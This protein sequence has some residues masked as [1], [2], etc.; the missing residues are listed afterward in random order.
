[1]NDVLHPISFIS[2]G[3][4]HFWNSNWNFLLPVGI[5]FYTFQTISYTIDVYYRIAPTYALLEH[6]FD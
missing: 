6:R 2:D 1:M 3:N 5:S 4:L